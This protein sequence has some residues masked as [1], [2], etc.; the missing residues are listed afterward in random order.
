MSESIAELRERLDAEPSNV[1]TFEALERA[2]VQ[3]QDIQELYR[4]Y[5][6]AEATLSE[7]IPHFW[8]RLLRHVDQAVSRA[9]DEEQ[10]G[11]LYLLIGQI[12]EDKLGRPDQA[13]ASYQQA[14]RMC[15][16]LSEALDRARAIYSQAGNWDL[17]LRLWEM[18]ARNDRT[19]EAQAD[20]Y[21]AMG[22]V[23]LDQIGDGA[24]ATDH[25]RRALTQVPGHE[26]AQKILDD[27]AD[28]TRDWQGEISV[29]MSDARELQDPEA[30]IERMQEIL[31]FVIDRVPLDKVD[32]TAIIDELTG[33]DPK[34]IRSWVLAR[35]WYDRAGDEAAA[36]AAHRPLLE[37]LEGSARIDAL[38]EAATRAHNVSRF[39]EE[40]AARRALLKA[41]PNEPDNLQQLELLT[42]EDDAAATRLEIYIEALYAEAGDRVELLRKAAHLAQELERYEHAESLFDE[43]RE[44]QPDALDALAYLYERANQ[45][46]D[47]NAQY[48]LLVDWAPL[49]PKDEQ[50]ER[51]AEAALLADT[52][53]DDQ[54]NAINAWQK[55][56]EIYPND[57]DAR[58]A[59]SDLFTRTKSW[60]ALAQ[61]LE[62]ER[63]HPEPIDDPDAITDAL[64]ALYT[65]KLEN[66]ER[67]LVHLHRRVDASP[68]DQELGVQLR[69]VARR[70]NVLD[71]VRKDLHMR[72]GNAAESE[73][74]A[75][76]DE[77]ARLELACEQIEAA[78]PWLDELVQRDEVGVD[79][80]R[81]RRDIAENES[82]TA[83]L[84]ELQKVISARLSDSD[85]AS[86]EALR[87]AGFAEQA[88]DH[89]SAY[90]AFH[91]VLE[92]D[93]DGHTEARHGAIRALEAL[94]QWDALANLLEVEL[95]HDDQAATHA[96]LAQIAEQHLD[97]TERAVRHRNEAIARDPSDHTSA[98]ALIA[99]YAQ[100]EA[101]QNLERVATH[102][103]LLEEGWHAGFDAWKRA[104]DA[105]ESGGYAESDLP[106]VHEQLKTWA[107][108]LLND[109]PKRYDVALEHAQRK[110][111]EDAWLAA[112]DAARDAA[113]TTAEYDAIVRTAQQTEDVEKLSVYWTRAAE[114]AENHE[115]VASDGWE[116]RAAA[117]RATPD[118]AALRDAFTKASIAQ[119]NIAAY[120]EQLDAQLDIV[121]EVSRTR[122]LRDLGVL[123]AGPLADAAKARAYWERL[124]EDHP[125]DREALDALYA[126]YTTDAHPEERL[127]IVSNLLQQESGARRQ[128]LEKEKAQLLDT[129]LARPD[130]AVEA[131]RVVQ[132]H[133]DENTRHANERIEAL[134]RQTE[135][136][137]DLETF[138]SEQLGLAGTAED[139]AAALVRRGT[140]RIEHQDRSEEGVQDLLNV[141]TGFSDTPAA[142]DA[143][144][145]L[146]DHVDGPNEAVVDTLVDWHDAKGRAAT[147]DDLL[148]KRIEKFGE[149]DGPRW[150][151]LV[152][153]LRNRP[154]QQLRLIE[155]WVDYQIAHSDT[156]DEAAE[157]MMWS[158]ESEHSAQLVSV[159]GKRLMQVETPPQWW[160][161]YLTMAVE[162]GADTDNVL[163]V[164]RRLRTLDE[165]QAEQIDD[166]IE[167]LLASVGRFQEQI[168]V[169]AARAEQSTPE[170]ASARYVTAGQIAEF[171]CEDPSQAADF[172]L[173][174]LAQTPT[175]EELVEP[176]IRNLFAAERW[177]EATEQLRSARDNFSS[178][179]N[180]PQWQAQ[181]ARAASRAGESDESVY[182]ALR[183]AAEQMPSAPAVA[184]GLADLAFREGADEEVAR[185]AATL[186]L[187]LGVADSDV[188]RELHERL[189]VLSPDDE[190]K[191]RALIALG[192]LLRHDEAF[193]RRAWEVHA[194]ALALEPSNATIAN[195]LE[196]L[197][198]E[199]QEWRATSELLAEHGNAQDTEVGVPLLERAVRI[200]VEHTNDLERAVHYQ[201]DLLKKAGD[202]DDRLATLEQWY[203]TL[204]MHEDTV[205][206]L[207]RR[208]ALAQTDG[209]SQVLQDVRLRAV[210]IT[211]ERLQLHEDTVRRWREIAEAHPEAR[212]RALEELSRIHRAHSEW[213]ELDDVL[214]QRINQSEQQEQ[215]HALLNEQATLREEALKN[216][217]GAIESLHRISK[218]DLEDIDAL[219]ELDRLYLEIGDQEAR[220]RCIQERFGRSGHIEDRLHLA[221]AGLT[222]E[223][224][225]ETALQSLC[226]LI[227]QSDEVRDEALETLSNVADNQPEF[228]NLERWMLLA[229]ALEDANDL[230][231]AARA[232]LQVANAVEAEEIKKARRWLAVE[233]RYQALDALE[234]AAQMAV[235]LWRTEGCGPERQELVK[236]VVR[237]A[238]TEALYADAVETRLENRPNAHELRAD[239][240][241]WYLEDL[242]NEARRRHHLQVL[243]EADPKN[244]I[245]YADLL[246]VTPED[247]QASI[248]RLRMNA[249]PNDDER[250]RLRASLG[251]SLAKSD[252]AEDKLEAQQLLE[253]FRMTQ[254]TNEEV[255]QA[256]R[257]LLADGEHWSQLA[258]LIEEELWL[259]D[260]KQERVR[261]LIERARCRE[262]EQALPSML[263][264]GWFDVLAEDASQPDAI[265]VLTEIAGELDDPFLVAR[266]QDRLELA[267]ERSQRWEDLYEL[268]LKRSE[269]LQAMERTDTLQRAAKL[270]QDRLQDE[271]RVFDTHLRLIQHD[272]SV[273]GVL[274]TLVALAQTQD[275]KDQLRQAIGH[276]LQGA[277]LDPELRTRLRRRAA[278]LK[279]ASPNEQEQAIEELSV[280]FDARK[281]WQIVE[282][283]QELYKEQPEAYIAWLHQRADA[284]DDLETR[285]RLLRKASDVLIQIPDKEEQAGAI[286]ESIY[287]LNPS[288]T[289]AEEID[290]LYQRAGLHKLRATF[291]AARLQD[292]EHIVSIIEL[293]RRLH[294]C[295]VADEALWAEQIKHLG[296][297]WDAIESAQ[298]AGEAP[299]KSKQD[300]AR[301]SDALHDTIA[302]WSQTTDRAE[303]EGDMLD[304]LMKRV[305]VADVDDQL[306]NA[307]I[308]VA[309]S[310]ERADLLWEERIRNHAENVS[311]QKAWQTAATALQDAPERDARGATIERLANQLKNYEEAAALLRHVS[312]GHLDTRFGLALRAARIDLEELDLQRRA[313]RTL[314]NVL[315]VKPDYTPARNM[316]R[317]I[318]DQDPRQDLRQRIVSVLIDTAAEPA[319]KASLSML[320]AHASDARHDI[321]EA[322]KS[323]R[324][325]LTYDPGN[326]EART[327]LLERRNDSA[328][329]DVLEKDLLPVL[330]NENAVDALH[331]T[332]EALAA[333][334]RNDV[335]KA[336][337]AAEVANLLSNTD[338]NKE[339]ALNAWLQ[340]LRA[341]PHS[342]SYLEN[343]VNAVDSDS[344]AILLVDTLESIAE[345]TKTD[346]VKAS[347]YAAAGHAQ[348][349]RLGDTQSG[350]ANLLRAMQVNPRNERALDGLETYYLETADYNGLATLLE[351]RLNATDDPEARR[352]LADRVVTLLRGELGRPNDAAKV[353]EQ[354]LL[355][356]GPDEHLLEELRASYREAG[357][358][359]G[360][361]AT[362]ERLA[363]MATDVDERIDQR[364]E[365]LQLATT[366][367]H[368]A[369]RALALS[370]AL[371]LDDQQHPLALSTRADI[372]SQRD[373]RLAALRAQFAVV[374]LHADDQVVLSA[375]AHAFATPPTQQ[376]DLVLLMTQLTVAAIERNLL[377]EIDASH[378]AA[379]IPHLPVA[380]QRRV[381]QVILDEQDVNERRALLV[382]SLR[383]LRASTDESLGAQVIDA[384]E[385]YAPLSEDE[386]AA[387]ATWF[388]TTNQYDR[389]ADALRNLVNSTED[390][391]KKGETLL[392]IAKMEEERENF[393]VLMSLYEEALSTGLRSASLYSGLARGYEREQNWDGL[394]QVLGEQL[395]GTSGIERGRLLRRVANVYRT[396]LHD[397][398]SAKTFLLEAMQ[399]SADTATR[400]DLLEVHVALAEHD[401]AQQLIDVLQQEHLHRAMRHRVELARGRL[402]LQQGDWP[403]AKV[404]LSA[405][406][407]H[408]ASHAGTLLSLAQAHI[409]LQ[410]W[411]DA[412][413]A[414]Q[415]ALVNQDQLTSVEKATTFVLLARVQAQEGSLDRAREFVTRALRLEPTLEDAL[416]LENEL[417]AVS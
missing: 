220:Y 365:A 21:T 285:I 11:R 348:L 316:M 18:Q 383:A 245:V 22:R 167:E 41:V 172:Y 37:L 89:Q 244:E 149:H 294:Q 223:G 9:E 83:R 170:E 40:I 288:L 361:V 344:D 140:L 260:D 168:D 6:R 80:L 130:D 198:G 395:E 246:S 298:D 351:A 163:T 45:R 63:V 92:R 188:R 104:A 98:Q 224:E 29:E 219:N 321:Y 48:E 243:F 257:S 232:N 377:P 382:A 146:R 158:R 253:S 289:G 281:P 305:G 62:E 391:Q 290:A 209:Q 56:R 274:D 147:G 286:L 363:T 387:I 417:N 180:K 303:R 332:I 118:D 162:T 182:E 283:V 60:D 320:G 276:G 42:K 216:V 2:L 264:E 171:E 373:D 284:V 156:R 309:S 55:R 389:A 237:Q 120:A 296:T 407:E 127:V 8:M 379:W 87:L 259:T 386:N 112:A 381:V 362:L 374:D 339:G 322:K 334:E 302:R 324:A 331:K 271:Q 328:W 38:R 265:I 410:E 262:R 192:D 113:N 154:D 355:L 295:F 14:Y 53:L 405:A 190:R 217:E 311:L 213:S 398:H 4:L 240:V 99:Y 314:Q 119:G 235:D 226:N 164:L 364:T 59:L 79:L 178:S 184:E 416:A 310:E 415:A 106:A 204:Q 267:Y 352:T 346:E 227:T 325:A 255:N 388:E 200:E 215:R 413:E 318:L 58:R 406:H 393:S 261:L 19:A 1:Q 218:E 396:R 72:I 306:F 208:A 134:L 221:R 176:L 247:E 350:V 39:D 161:D 313:T 248:L 44:A 345:D 203:E 151:R 94:A 123:Y 254:S 380:E 337:Y 110:D 136:Y 144:V 301:W 52:R 193:Y 360:E 195:R 25:A 122:M 242:P 397:D 384:L 49:L 32:A 64:I 404:A 186:H 392:K 367:P 297:W 189:V 101:W 201:E 31:H 137:D 71:D 319:E 366:S 268:L 33:R 36:E 66:Y 327:F 155:Q 75:L 169:I 27:Y 10:R 291:W 211:D 5:E 126:L 76:V 82:D 132:A 16:R 212:V 181:L 131:W 402:A 23:C 15:P 24:R 97:D 57:P 236:N 152:Q 46:D 107:Q 197:A 3:A 100:N 273:E 307:R 139:A 129:A 279:A 282:D 272:P 230:A 50:A 258:S 105:L 308:E 375:L 70:A 179:P 202:S 160:P 249:T 251:L 210:E 81:V 95:K 338:G 185:K 145:T 159:W 194:E 7:Q 225:R 408:L 143:D 266:V 270:A 411:G 323:V 196:K 256:L 86:D 354:S 150:L 333:N 135:R 231:G 409:A 65:T 329:H 399:T 357:N 173:R 269:Q 278:L 205:R 73:R 326:T 299:A 128:E 177:Q 103:S 371:L 275:Q 403:A 293:H 17:V 34:N 277:Q 317:S 54:E 157:M 96:R 121:N 88:A 138:F 359:K 400:L 412:Q 90:D 315:E 84:I 125:A 93:G 30:S 12:Y 78:R 239:L 287:V 280:L 124:R 385:S 330:R 353:L 69:E 372:L 20:I 390:P 401:E 133:G 342:P 347:L 141:I 300:R 174:A 378:L 166:A 343:A 369:D 356:T 222:L 43:L 102:T 175:R 229:Q 13:N 292:D 165:A 142:S 335:K 368:L 191:L 250:Q 252:N 199:L 117:W 214:T 233:Q 111:D 206:T 148:Q 340:A 108:N 263:V 241:Q 67:A 153:R 51:W 414:L 47:A 183:A 91:A 187:S 207:D 116:E 349:E 28:L 35:N 228:L 341:H 358:V 312:E 114:L 109:A 370:E 238:Q 74:F 26:G 376:K 336:A 115:H 85:E 61:H 77:L 68:H 304:A 394:L 234:E